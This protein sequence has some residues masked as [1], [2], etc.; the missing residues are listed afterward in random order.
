V[1]EK[2][3]SLECFEDMLVAAV[4]VAQLIANMNAHA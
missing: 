4:S 3:M 2:P 1:L